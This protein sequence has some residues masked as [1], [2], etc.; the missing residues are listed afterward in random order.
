L[1]PVL[2]ITRLNH[3]PILELI[4]LKRNIS[5]IQVI[6]PIVLISR[7]MHLSFLIKTEKPNHAGSM[8]IIRSS[9]A[10]SI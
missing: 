3:A 8:F 5:R 7:F 4:F 9:M 1:L 10:G 6:A 2:A